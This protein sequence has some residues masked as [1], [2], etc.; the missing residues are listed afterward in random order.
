MRVKKGEKEIVKVGAHCYEGPS[1]TTTMTSSQ[2]GQLR[3]TRFVR[4]TY[5]LYMDHKSFYDST[6]IYGRRRRGITPI[7]D[8][9]KLQRDFVQM[10]LSH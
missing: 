2:K 4:T 10:D 1:K 7:L 3:S 8:F 9:T 5:A 6:N